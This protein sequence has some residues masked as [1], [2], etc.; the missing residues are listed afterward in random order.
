[1]RIAALLLGLAAGLFALLAPIA[2]RTD[3][4]TPFLALWD[5]SA[6]QQLLGQAIWYAIP[7]AAVLGGILVTFAPGLALVPLAAAALGW[8]GMGL[9]M[10][11]Q[12]DYRLIAPAA[13]SGLAAILALISAELSLRRRRSER[14]KRRSLADFEDD[15]AGDEI[16]R[17]AALRMDP[18]AISREQAAQ[19]PRRVV[20]LDLD[21][22]AP[23]ARPAGPP[24]RWQD[25]DAE[26]VQRPRPDIWGEAIRP[27]REKPAVVEE[28]ID[29]EP[30]PE[31]VIEEDQS[32]AQRG[33]RWDRADAPM[34]QRFGH[35]GSTGPTIVQVR[36]TPPPEPAPPRTVPQPERL[37]PAAAPRAAS[38]REAAAP[39]WPEPELELQRPFR[40]AEQPARERRRSSGLVAALLAVVAVLLL[41]ALT[42]GGYLAYRD[43]WVDRVAAMFSPQPGTA[44]PTEVAAIP[45]LPAAPEPAMAPAP[46]AAASTLVLPP[47]PELASTKSQAKPAPAPAALAVLPSTPVAAATP[48][49]SSGSYSDPFAYCSAVGTIDH[50]DGR[51]SGPM[52]TPA[53]A[54]TLSV[55][56]NTARDRVHWRCANGTVMACT[57]F[58][59]PIC[60]VSPSVEEMRAYCAQYPSAPQLMAPGGVW[61]CVDG[62]PQLP[63]GASW[64]IDSRGF[65]T[66]SW[67]VVN[68]PTA[69]A[70]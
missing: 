59:G 28:F 61:S 69:S 2:L 30:E 68:P 24:P 5:G 39:L 12:F 70:G 55:P 47:E 64:P 6:N 40:P 9:A 67:F 50:V 46:E 11:D 17:E 52:T 1:M 20:E 3:L 44:A 45:E 48:A 32:P 42:A 57:S 56:E 16:E 14:R 54:R 58:I 31:Q 35:T 38:V 10:P 60:D 51:Y 7:A 36:R 19:Q 65:R 8:I 27:E 62:K 33:F 41:G 66:D 22:V 43:G 4:M 29:L 23:A 13:A 26:P 34:G 18:I 15:D 49:T 53:I 37:A 25:L 21:D 63:E